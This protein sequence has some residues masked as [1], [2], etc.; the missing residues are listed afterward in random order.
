MTRK[1]T[2][3]V[4]RNMIA[5]GHFVYSERSHSFANCHRRGTPRYAQFQFLK[6]RIFHYG[7]SRQEIDPIAI[8]SSTDLPL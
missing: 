7:F 3:L 5:D 4:Y 6:I 1:K 2:L 8:G